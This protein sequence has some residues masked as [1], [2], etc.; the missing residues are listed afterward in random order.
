MGMMESFSQVKK[1]ILS[2]ETGVVEAANDKGGIMEGALLI[3]TLI[4]IACILVTLLGMLSNPISGLIGGAIVFVIEATITIVVL[5]V[6]SGVF[7]VASNMLGGKSRFGKS[8]YLLSM[9]WFQTMIL[10]IPFFIAYMLVLASVLLSPFALVVTVP[11]MLLAY[12]GV[13][14][15]LYINVLV[16]KAASGLSSFKSILAYFITLGVLM[17][18]LVL[19]LIVLF[20]PAISSMLSMMKPGLA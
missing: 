15:C 8:V 11:L 2:P 3:L 19:I 14:Y 18:V 13:F 9:G 7:H 5:L 16:L 10:L 20:G 1:L 4:A 12:S 17:A 6:I